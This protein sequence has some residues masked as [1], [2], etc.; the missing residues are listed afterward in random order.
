MILLNL[1][2]THFIYAAP[3]GITFQGQLLKDSVV[4][5]SP[6]VDL[7]IRVT[8]MPMIN[9]RPECVLFEETFPLN[10]TN[11]NGIF[12]VTLG[13]GV[14]T[15][16]DLGLSVSNVFQNAGTLSSLNCIGAPSAT[17]YTPQPTDSRNIYV[18]FVDGPDTVAFSAPYVIESVPYAFEAERLSTAASSGF[19]QTSSDTTQSKVDAIFASTPYAE[20][21]A[22]INGTSTSF[23]GLAGGNLNLGS[24]RIGVGTTNPSSDL[25]FGGNVAR[26]IAMERATSSQ[27]NNLTVAAGGATS[28]STNQN[29]G[30]L[31][32][33]AGMATGNGGSGIALNIVKSFQGN[34]TTDR[35]PNYAALTISPSGNVGIGEASPYAFSKLYVAS[36]STDVFRISNVASPRMLFEALNG[37]GNKFDFSNIT[38]GIQTTTQ[39]SEGG[40]LAISTAQSGTTKE[41]ARFDG[42]GNVGIGTTSPGSQLDVRGQK[43]NFSVGDYGSISMNSTPGGSSFNFQPF[44]GNYYLSAGTTNIGFW[45]SQTAYNPAQQIG[46]D[47]GDILLRTA[48]AVPA[49]GVGLNFTTGLIVKNSSYVGVNTLFPMNPFSA[50]PAQYQTGLATQSGTTITGS[51]TMWTSDLIGSQ[52]VFADGVAGGTILSVSSSSSMIVSISQ[53]KPN[54]NYYI[55]YTGLQ[56]SS[57]GN[58]GINTTS[59]AT[60]LDLNGAFSLRASSAP[61]LSPVAQARMYFDSTANQLMISQNG[62]AYG[63]LLSTSGGQ[64]ISGAETFS[65]AVTAS[66]AGTGLSVTNNANV[67][68]SLTSSSFASSGA[69]SVTSP[70]FSIPNVGGL[71]SNANCSIGISNCGSP[72]LFSYGG[73]IELKQA[74]R[75]TTAGAYIALSTST[76]T[77][78]A[79][80]FRDYSGIGMGADAASAKLSLIT[81]STSRL[82]IDSAGNVGIGTTS[83]AGILDVEGGSN[84]AAINLVAGNS[85]TSTTAGAVTLQSGSN[86]SSGNGAAG[87]LTLSSGTS[88]G[89]I[90]GGALNLNGGYAGGNGAGG[91]INIISGNSLYATGGA[92]NLT[93]GNGG[94]SPGA[95][96]GNVN[97]TAGTGVNSGY[98]GGNIILQP[99][100]GLYSAAPGKVG[101]NTTSPSAT[102]DVNGSMVIANGNA[103]YGKDTAGN[104]QNLVTVESYN[105]LSFGFI[106]MNTMNWYLGGTPRMR[107]TGSGFGI[108]TISPSEMLE[109]AG[110]IKLSGNSPSIY[111]ARTGTDDSSGRIDFAANTG[112]NDG[113]AMTLYGPNYSG[114]VGQLDFIAGNNGRITF[115]NYN[116]AAYSH[117]MDILSNG[118]VGVGVLT[119]GYKLDVGGDLNI[120]SANLLRFGGNQVC[121]STGCTSPSDL[122]LKENIQPL[123]NALENILDLR[124]VSYDWQDKE[125][126]NKNKQI[127]LIAQEVEKIYPEAISTDSQS[128]IKSVAYDHL[129]APIIESI[130]SIYSKLISTDSELA[131]LKLKSEQLESEKAQMTI[132]MD[133]LEKENAQMLKR[134]ARLEMLMQ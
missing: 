118:N 115:Q 112:S 59:P 120:A 73:E 10:M 82:A 93:A 62:S 122:R 16:N 123:E 105:E 88:K 1:I 76:M 39:G 89:N 58:V 19:L 107:L 94:T 36:D 17:A 47:H 133:R 3:Q 21:L 125:R 48:P 45:A 116:S 25:S 37:S 92:L 65:G 83:P 29:G 32:L 50:S 68:G 113:A 80:G 52:F 8:S 13:T 129:V 71:Y 69:S 90:V 4:V 33:N 51:G 106:G 44:F 85:A 72:V 42:A 28:S 12:A 53:T 117:Y 126:F 79:F 55:N 101:I 11:S 9:T 104:N 34:G 78:P 38:S 60:P 102:L 75:A 131:A 30:T 109:V 20:L 119:P 66:A 27:G 26:T 128:G 56:V 46:F 74:M 18:S 41:V 81:N 49:A 86:T 5:E 124:G 132:R 97:V 40:Y 111:A 127:G 96:G 61:P 99:G 14:R 43:I 134:M 7:T 57:S 54:L 98:S 24:G 22:L 103:L 35:S 108:G 114:R 70:A 31:N 91:P 87:A 6:T 100:V 110:K 2:L 64:T 130:K 121:S 63:S 15:S 67:G 95:S 77:V 23:A 84:S